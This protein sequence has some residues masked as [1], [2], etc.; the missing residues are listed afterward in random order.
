[1]IRLP[2]TAAAVTAPLVA[3][4]TAF[5][6]I[7]IGRSLTD[8]RQFRLSPVLV[9]GRL[10]PATNSLALGGLGSG[11]ST[12]SK[13]RLLREISEHGHQG[14]V[15]D[16][17]GE[18]GTSGEWAALTRAVGGLVVE[19][20][21]FTLNPCSPILPREVR[22]QLVR[23]LIAAVEPDALSHHATH[24]VQHVMNDRRA[25]DLHGVVDALVDP[26]AGRW[27]ASRLSEWGEGAAIALS[28][29]TEGSLTGLFD[30]ADT[31]LPPTDR[32]LISFDFSRLDR[33]SPAIPALMA[34]IA[35]WVEHVW[36]RQSTAPHRHL[37]L[38]EAWQVLLSPATAELIQ[39]L[40]KNSRKAALSLDCVM[41]TLSDLGDGRAQDLAKLCEIVHVGRLGPEEAAV[42]GALLGLPAWAVDRIPMLGPGEAVWKVGPHYVDVVATT[43]SEEE[44]ELTDTSRRRRAAQEAQ[45][46]TEQITV[47]PAS[48]AG[49]EAV[50]SLSEAV[51]EA[52]TA[53]TPAAA[54]PVPVLAS[55]AGGADAP[56]SA[57]AYALSAR[58]QVALQAA[59]EGRFSE[60]ADVAV[61]GE[62]EDIRA[63]GID[64]PQALAWTVVRAHVAELAGNEAH[65]A[66]LR[67]TVARMANG[68]GNE[69]FEQPTGEQ[70][71]WYSVDP[72]PEPATG[73]PP[74]PLTPPRRRRRLWPYVASAIVL[75]LTTAAVW[76]SGDQ[77]RQQKR[78]TERAAAY[79]G[80][81]MATL[82]MAG[83]LTDLNAQWSRETNTVDVELRMYFET[84]AKYLRIES[85]GKSDTSVKDDGYTEDPQLSL[86]VSDIN[87][88]VSVRVL[89]GGP[90]WKRG[91][92]LETRTVRLSPTGMA[93]DADTGKVLSR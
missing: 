56:R 83:I 27:P 13:V 4:D 48:A 72:S 26:R 51:P 15:V 37:V 61:L 41:H 58:H 49:P 7:P 92:P 82:K 29:Y 5:P 2:A 31:R 77:D 65:S 6:G 11:K 45:A 19:A 34:A 21:T 76:Q 35:C 39:R 8:G 50:T 22:E 87:A 10:L 38:E 71:Q 33:N 54:A 30:S 1:M 70:A 32:P 62:R 64:S 47:E 67:A 59:R 85:G 14:V 78:E 53:H 68:K 44:A 36:L 91:A 55:V 90:T 46:A 60:A 74:A 69:W 28:R 88:D 42:V 12:T 17:Y 25:T 43:L 24:A 81:A 89:I 40:L 75:A 66:R 80:R 9:D 23:S 18:D 20:G 63:H 16:S 79:Q 3:S 57:A 52:R 73:A 86:P 84:G 93:Y